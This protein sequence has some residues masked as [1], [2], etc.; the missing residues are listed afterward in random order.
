MEGLAW[1]NT[2]DCVGWLKAAR[3]LSSL[4][5]GS[6]LSLHTTCSNTETLSPQLQ[7]IDKIELLVLRAAVSLP[8]RVSNFQSI[9]D[10]N[11]CEM[12]RS[13]TIRYWLPC[14]SLSCRSCPSQREFVISSHSLLSNQFHR[15]ASCILRSPP[16]PSC[17]EGSLLFIRPGHGLKV[18]PEV[19]IGV[20]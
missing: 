5:A 8:C 6:L 3:S 12:V 10:P 4:D 13:G 17:G 18:A 19:C 11:M 2:D 7:E 20:C 1:G 9:D 14:L 15:I 16:Y